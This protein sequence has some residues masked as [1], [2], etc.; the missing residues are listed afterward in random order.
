[1]VVDDGTAT[2]LQLKGDGVQ[3]L[4]AISLIRHVSEERSGEREL[5]LAIEEPEAH[6]RPRAVP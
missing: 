6:L 5:V 4:A 2:D 1:M 3:S